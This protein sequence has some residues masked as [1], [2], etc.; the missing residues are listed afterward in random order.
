MNIKRYLKK[1]KKAIKVMEF[2]KWLAKMSATSHEVEL[3]MKVE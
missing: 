1:R 2:G 3:A